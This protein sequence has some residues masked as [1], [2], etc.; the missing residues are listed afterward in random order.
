MTSLSQV[1]ML[2]QRGRPFC[3]TGASLAL[4]LMIGEVQAQDFTYTNIN[5]AITITGYTGPG[6]AV[7]IPTTI[8]FLPVASVG[9]HAFAW[10]QTL[11]SVTIPNSV[12]N[13][14]TYGFYNCNYL[15]EVTI[16][17]S[18]KTIGS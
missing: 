6:G 16:G 13:I 8:D 9:D 15:T 4:W 3:A 2:T 14:D 10:A 18:V 5:G 11:M 7:T 17:N 12:T 1:K